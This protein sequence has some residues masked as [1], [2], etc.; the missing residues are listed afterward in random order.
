MGSHTLMAPRELKLPESIEARA[1]QQSIRPVR[2][3]FGPLHVPN[4]LRPH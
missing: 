4:S 3:L 2:L 1:M